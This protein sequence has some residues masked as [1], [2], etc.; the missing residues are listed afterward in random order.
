MKTENVVLVSLGVSVALNAFLL[1]VMT[2]RPVAPFGHMME[3]RHEVRQMGRFEG[4]EQRMK[5]ALVVLPDE[6]KTKVEAIID[7]SAT[8]LKKHFGNMKSN[9]DE[10][11]KVLTAPKF[12]EKKFA[13]VSA[14]LAP[15]DD[16]IKDN[17]STMILSIAK[18]L[19]DEDRIKFFNKLAEDRKKGPEGRGDRHWG[20]DQ[21][22]PMM[23][24]RDRSE[25]HDFQGKDDDKGHRAENHK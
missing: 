16:K 12:D 11:E 9:I 2:S 22:P 23:M 20:D 25:L 14:L 3:R 7:Q 19:P 13:E 18:L 4:P 6:Y 10:M 17:M 15:K 8:N 21:R 1:G 5:S 24:D